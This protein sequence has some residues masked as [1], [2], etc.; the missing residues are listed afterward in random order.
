MEHVHKIDIKINR[1]FQQ[2]E[3]GIPCSWRF[4]TEYNPR[5]PHRVIV[6]PSGV[7]YRSLT[8]VRHRHQRAHNLSKCACHI[9]IIRV[10]CPYQL[11]CYFYGPLSTCSPTCLQKL[12]L[13]YSAHDTALEDVQAKFAVVLIYKLFSNRQKYKITRLLLL[14]LLRIII[15]N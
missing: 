14:L 5:D 4:S 11:C 3:K 1:Y 10:M 13:Y 2:V 12:I 15:I 7:A 9:H 6:I 8:S